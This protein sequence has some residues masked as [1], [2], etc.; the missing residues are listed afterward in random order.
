VEGAEAALQKA[1]TLLALARVCAP[2][3][4]VVSRRGYFVG[5]YVASGGKGARLPL[6]TVERTDRVRVV[7]RV[8]DHDIPHVE[9]GGAAEVVL[10]ALPG[11]RYSGRVARVGFAVDPRTRTM[12]AEIDLSNA[13]QQLRPGMAGTATLHLGKGASP[14][15]G[16]PGGA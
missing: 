10:D 3:D 6:L 8:P 14:A 13:H 5:D 9:V 15:P 12:R 7:V 16:R 1:K 11:R 4:G 2:F